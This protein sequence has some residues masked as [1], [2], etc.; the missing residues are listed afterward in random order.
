MGNTGSPISQLIP[1]PLRVGSELAARLLVIAAALAVV[2]FLIIQ[3]RVVV[4]PVVIAL[5]LAALLAPVVRTAVEAG[6]PRGPATGIVL[7]GGIALFG[8]VISGVVNAFVAG[9]PELRDQLIQ[10]YQETI[11][12]L[13]A[14][15]P[16][17]VSL[18]RLNNLPGE[19]QHSIA[20]NSQAITSGA[21]STAATLTE[22]LSGM[23]LGLFVLI[24]FLHDGSKIWGFLIK[25]VPQA[26]RAR[27]DTAGERAFASLVGYTRAT[28]VVAFV[29]AIGIG[30]G[31][32]IIGTPLRIP[33]A[34]LVFLGAFIPVVGSLLS[35]SVAVLVT[36]V[37]NGPVQS[38]IVF[39]IVIVV[40]QV[41]S[42]VLQPI[43][44]G[45]AVQLHPLAV[46]LAVAGGVVIAGITGA[47][48]AVP[49]VA[50]L[51]SGIRSLLAT[52]EAHASQID[53]LDPL[54]ADARGA[55]PQE[56]RRLRRL[57]VRVK[58]LF[59]GL[60]SKAGS[61]QKTGSAS[62]TGSAPKAGGGTNPA[63]DAE[64]STDAE[65]DAQPDAQPDADKRDAMRAQE[66]AK[67]EG[68]NA[69]S[70]DGPA[71]T[72]TKSETTTSETTTSET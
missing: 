29:D 20:A 64:T 33:L 23:L 5:L 16:F 60:A 53:S 47:L 43:L 72:G 67:R 65:P 63:A 57:A 25:V 10:S 62:K 18:E 11:K 7:V 68:E 17:R 35:G 13:L 30:V 4:I 54:H 27:V 59:A 41:E 14:G 46:V 48:V 15:P 66:A 58:E 31:L 34:A 19:L 36:L 45:R 1:V 22:V 56:R 44:M 39:G 32:W 49:L 61:G 28:V 51:T 42:H 55:E 6:V 38:L 69:A 50:V 21:L 52:S 37:A 12:P 8:I 3:L 70:V 2:V 40:M 71:E 9:V 26:Q 24:F